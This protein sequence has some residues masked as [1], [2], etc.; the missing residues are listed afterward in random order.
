MAEGWHFR[1]GLLALPVALGCAGESKSTAPSD[2]S[3]KEAPR[4]RWSRFDEVSSWS[5]VNSSAFAT[6][7]HLVKPSYAVVRVSPEARSGYLALVTD[8]V[9]AEGATIAMFHQSRD[10]AQRGPVYVMEKKRIGGAGGA[11]AP[12]TNGTAAPP[13]NGTAAPP[14]NGTA[15]WTFL[16]L[17]SEGNL[18]AENLNVCALCHRGGVAD[19]LFGLPRSLAPA[20]TT[21]RA[22]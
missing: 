9:L 15:E 3:Q 22:E 14:T 18:T 19:H 1:L 8:T 4:E 21:S 13:T 20:P 16:A 2:P 7:G 5:P 17:D 11:G 6:R 10:G 12:P